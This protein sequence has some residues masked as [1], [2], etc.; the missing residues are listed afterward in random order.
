MKIMKMFFL[1]FLCLFIF[2]CGP[3]LFIDYRV[4]EYLNENIIKDF[5]NKNNKEHVIS[6]SI[7][8]SKF[9]VFGFIPFPPY[10]DPNHIFLSIKNFTDFKK[11]K[12]NSYIIKVNEKIKR[13]K[14]KPKPIKKEIFK[15][16]A[17]LYF[18]EF[19]SYKDG[20]T[21][22]IIFDVSILK[23]GVW[24]NTIVSKKFIYSKKKEITFIE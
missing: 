11:I 16:Y 21:I 10:F 9:F 24:D 7:G 22:E 5:K 13:K 1:M 2:G 17:A 20:D 19:T 15:N 23:N 12:I 6:I 18:K 14:I 8:G 4:K 3:G